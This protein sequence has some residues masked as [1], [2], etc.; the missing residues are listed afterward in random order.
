MKRSTWL[1]A[2]LALHGCSEPSPDSGESTPSISYE[3][4]VRCVQ[5]AQYFSSENG[6]QALVANVSQDMA[7]SSLQQV[8]GTLVTA[9]AIAMREAQKITPRPNPASDIGDGTEL[10]VQVRLETNAGNRNTV[11]NLLLEYS[12]N[13]ETNPALVAERNRP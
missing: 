1:V 4:A 8:P 5:L 12:R 6:M 9:R 10:S 2:I 13:C 3:Q 11:Q 7:R